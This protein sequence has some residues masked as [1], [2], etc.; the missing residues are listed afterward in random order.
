[1]GGRGRYRKELCLSFCQI[2]YMDNLSPLWN[3]KPELTEVKSFAKAHTAQLGWNPV[4]TGS[5]AQGGS[6]LDL[7]HT[8]REKGRE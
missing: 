4:A 7:H 2:F 8:T 5:P 1:M 3:R 6:T